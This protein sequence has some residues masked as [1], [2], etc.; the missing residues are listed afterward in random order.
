MRPL[1]HFIQISRERQKDS[2]KAAQ[3]VVDSCLQQKI[4]KRKVKESKGI[5]PTNGPNSQGS[6]AVKLASIFTVADRNFSFP[7]S[8]HAGFA[9]VGP[10]CTYENS[11]LMGRAAFRS[12]L[13]EN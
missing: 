6:G 11:L 4:S 12:Q 1:L 8:L 9:M 3:D 5:S 13:I 10:W 2:D 7:R